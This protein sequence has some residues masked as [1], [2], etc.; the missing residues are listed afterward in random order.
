MGNY[1]NTAVANLVTPQ[2]RGDVVKNLIPSFFP[3]QLTEAGKKVNTNTALTLS[4]FYCGVNSIANSIAMLP[5]S[6][7][8]R[9]DG[10]REPA[11]DHPAHY[12]LHNEPNSRMT[13]FTFKHIMVLAVLMRGNAYAYQERN[14]AGRVV[15]YHYLDPDS[16]TVI[17]K[18]RKLFYRVTGHKDLFNAD[19]IIH[20]PGLSFDGVSGKS[21][22]EHAADNLGVA[23][24]AQKFGSDSLHN[25][26][27]AQGVIESENSVSVDAKKRLSSAWVAAM[28]SEEKYR[29]PILDEGMK[30]KPITLKPQEAQFIETYASGVEDVARWLSVPL[31]MLHTKSE[32]GYNSMTHL[33][34]MYRSTAVQPLA[35]KFKQEIERKT[36]TDGERK[37]GYY[38]YQN[39][40]KIL[41]VDPEA[42]AKYYKDMIY[43]K[44]MS[45]NEVRE[46]E[47]M[48]PYVGGDD[49]LQMS[50]LLTPEQIE[51]QLKNQSNGAKPSN[52]DSQSSEGQS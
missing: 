51:A 22:I 26:G 28:S 33:S 36:F 15:G 39:Y 48:N 43:M 12:L 47:D 30:Y 50:N 45:P 10:I 49:K 2:K 21:V 27:I 6:V 37:K 16:V 13:A 41:Q 29:A 9:K 19:E 25:R 38:I 24:A 20:I 40:Q 32:G 8:V 11:Y 17:E 7:Y 46:L 1:F 14:N 42:R 34:I 5:F 31:H 4:A 18:D 3:M 52:Q 23:L 44:A 35:D